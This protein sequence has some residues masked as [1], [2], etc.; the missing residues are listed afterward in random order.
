MFR[1]G[2]NAAT[3]AAIEAGRLD[4]SAIESMGPPTRKER[5][6]FSANWNMT[7]DIMFYGLFRGYD[8]D[9]EPECRSLAA[10]QSGVY[11]GYVVPA[12]AV[13]QPENIE[14]GMKVNFLTERSH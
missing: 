7:D 13:R 1:G 12:V 10:N 6:C 11:G 4:M 8:S 9:P 2:G 3:L 5:C 14:F